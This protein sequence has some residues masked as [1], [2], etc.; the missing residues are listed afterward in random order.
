[1]QRAFRDIEEFFA[2]WPYYSAEAL[3]SNYLVSVVENTYCNWQEGSNHYTNEALEIY[4]GA[5]PPEILVRGASNYRK[6][7]KTKEERNINFWAEKI[8]AGG[9][10]AINEYFGRNK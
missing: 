9:M 3:D 4:R 7:T 5:D 10:A 8:R 6:T 1:M 2:V